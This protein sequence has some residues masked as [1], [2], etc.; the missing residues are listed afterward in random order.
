VEV[1]VKKFDGK[2]P[3]LRFAWWAIKEKNFSWL[4]SLSLIRVFDKAH[5]SY[6]VILKNGVVGAYTTSKIATLKYKPK[7]FFNKKF[8]AAVN[9]L[10]KNDYE[11][12]GHFVV[13]GEF[14]KKG[15]ASEV[16]K[17]F[18]GEEKKFYFIPTTKKLEEFYI[19][20]G[21]KVYERCSETILVCRKS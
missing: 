21:A 17:M 5:S 14:R 18:C 6:F 13:F 1:N 4:L 7:N 3:F 20:N 2:V 10:S 8:T 15:I 9:V 12:L 19:R 11:Y 16:V